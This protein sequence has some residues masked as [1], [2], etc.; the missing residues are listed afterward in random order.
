MNPSPLS[1]SPLHGTS[2]IGENTISKSRWLFA[3]ISLKIPVTVFASCMDLSVNML[4]PEGPSSPNIAQAR[5]SDRN[6]FPFTPRDSV[7]PDST[8]SLM[9][10]KKEVSAYIAFTS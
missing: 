1:Q 3:G 9:V 2:S 5:L 6:T 4:L 10:L 7:S 8:G